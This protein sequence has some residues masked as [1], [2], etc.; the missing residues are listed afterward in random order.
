MKFDDLAREASNAVQA[1]VENHPLPGVDR[2]G[3]WSRRLALALGAAAI[4]TGA[5]LGVTGLLGGD[6]IETIDEPSTTATTDT[7]TL[8]PS[9]TSTIPTVVTSPAGEG[10]QWLRVPHDPEVFAPDQMEAITNHN[11]PRMLGLV[12]SVL[13]DANIN[14][15]DLLNK[16]RNDIAYNACSANTC[17]LGKC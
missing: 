12:T 1:Q 5:V 17:C 11:V 3:S 2:R 13:A 6:V 8:E 7:T 10:G 4:V 9:T 16:S 14:V 15:I